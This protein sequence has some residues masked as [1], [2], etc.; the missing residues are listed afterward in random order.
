MVIEKLKLA[1]LSASQSLGKKEFDF[2]ELVRYF[3]FKRRWLSPDD[4]RKLIELMISKNLLREKMG[5]YVPNFNLKGLRVPIDFYISIND[6]KEVIQQKEIPASSREETAEKT[7]ISNAAEAFDEIVRRIVIS[8][9]EDKRKIIG[10]INKKKLELELIEAPV[11]AVLIA[12][13][14]GVQYED[15]IEVIEEDVV[16][17]S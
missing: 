5:K 6:L 2:D 17:E 9:G 7:K 10:E 1:I 3:S 15:L 12:A 13:E 11:A 4:A 16:N 14:K 8:T